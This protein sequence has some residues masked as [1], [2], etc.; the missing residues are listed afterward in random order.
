MDFLLIYFVD[1]KIR[2]SNILKLLRFTKCH[3]V[4][5][6]FLCREYRQKNHLLV[7]GPVSGRM[8]LIAGLLGGGREECGQSIGLWIENSYFLSN[9]DFVLFFFGGFVKNRFCDGFVN[10]AIVIRSG[11]EF[12][13]NQRGAAASG[14]T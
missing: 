1:P 9:T 7:P 13:R 12:R 11:N 6:N 14:P 2:P 10:I 4:K 5:K 3:N 8:V